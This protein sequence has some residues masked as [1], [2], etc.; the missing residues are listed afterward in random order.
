[1]SLW[2]KVSLCYLLKPNLHDST[3][4]Y[5]CSLAAKSEEKRLFSKAI[6]HKAICFS[7]LYKMKFENL[8]FDFLGERSK[9]KN[10]REIGDV[11]T[12]AVYV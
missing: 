4:T 3:F 8:T 10:Y 1:M 11:Y 5:T 6:S 2:M 12:Q 7:A 9:E